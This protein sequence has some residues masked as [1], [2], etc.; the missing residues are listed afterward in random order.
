MTDLKQT[1]PTK[2]LESF[3]SQRFPLSSEGLGKAPH[4]LDYIKSNHHIIGLEKDKN[5]AYRYKVSLCF[6]HCL[7]IGKFKHTYHNC[8]QKAKELLQDYCQHFPVKSQDFEDVELDE[9]PELQKY[10]EDGTTK[11]LLILQASSPTKIYMNVY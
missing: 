9:F 8:N 7:A 4:L 11:T 1:R 2:P 10:Y 6:F 3:S 5:N